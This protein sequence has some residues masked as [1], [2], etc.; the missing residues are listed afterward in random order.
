MRIFDG[1]F[2]PY[3]FFKIVV[4]ENLKNFSLTFDF[5][6]FITDSTIIIHLIS[7]EFLNF[8]LMN[9]N[10]WFWSSFACTTTYKIFRQIS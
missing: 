10:F 3:K 2:C 9:S 8:F 7:Q 4:S 5:T 1:V 6:C